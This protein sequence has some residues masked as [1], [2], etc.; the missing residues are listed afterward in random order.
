MPPRASRARRA[1][2]AREFEFTN[3]V[4]REY[5][6]KSEL[7]PV[8]TAAWNVHHTCP[9]PHGVWGSAWWRGL[10]RGT[11]PQTHGALRTRF[12]RIAAC[13]SHDTRGDDGHTRHQYNHQ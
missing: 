10:P 13:D 5:S 2:N 9:T 7:H 1:R 4:I 12:T 8:A 6:H 11:S 3:C